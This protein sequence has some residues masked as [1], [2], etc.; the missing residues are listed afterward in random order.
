MIKI[1]DFV[2]CTVK[3][4][5]GTTVFVQIEGNGE[6]AIVVS[7]IAPGRIRN[8]R[9]YVVPNKK[10]V[11]KVIR[12]DDKGNISLSLRRVSNKERNEVLEKIEKEK[13]FSSI[14]KAIL[15]EKA[16][17][18]LNKIKSDNQNLYEFVASCKDNPTSLKKYFSQSEV[19]SICKILNSKGEKIVEVKKE[20][21]LSS[22]LPN[23]IILIKNI[24][25]PYKNVSYL[26]AGRYLIKIS[27][28]SY[29]KANQEMLKI[30]EEIEAKAKKDKLDFEINEK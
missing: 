12:I 5:V 16:P 21:S 19:D 26:A 18:T 3:E 13:E 27:S 4:I 10:I 28:D 15:K 8:L 17:E 22:F 6:G 9:D 23:G 20:I 2:L 11:C 7:E 1:D 25:I 29:K 14:V 30:T 24:L